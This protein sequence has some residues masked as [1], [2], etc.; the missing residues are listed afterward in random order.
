[1]NDDRTVITSQAAR[2]IWQANL[3]AEE[4]DRDSYNRMSRLVNT[5]RELNELTECVGSDPLGFFLSQAYDERLKERQEINRVL[6]GEIRELISQ[7]VADV[8]P[9]SIFR[10]LATTGLAKCSLQDF[11]RL[12]LVKGAGEGE[13]DRAGVDARKDDLDRILGG[14]REVVLFVW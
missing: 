12:L 10:A 7:R 3:K 11:L 6:P 8:T 14:E 5:L 9:D 1:M 4:C 2:D 13:L